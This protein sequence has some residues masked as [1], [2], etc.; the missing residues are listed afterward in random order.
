MVVITDGRSDDIFNTED[1]AQKAH[2]ASIVTFS[3][4]VG[5]LTDQSELGT[6]ASK[7]SCTHLYFV[8]VYQ[9]LVSFKVN[10]LL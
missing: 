1:A 4:G 3:V 9:N 8:S 2:D 5:N 7:P 6:L 10:T